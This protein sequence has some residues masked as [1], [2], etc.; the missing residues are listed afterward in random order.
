MAALR[1]HW[2]P[3]LV[4]EERSLFAHEFLQIRAVGRIFQIRLML[5]AR[6]HKPV[7]A[8]GASTKTFA[9]FSTPNVNLQE[10]NT[11][12]FIEFLVPRPL[13]KSKKLATVA[14]IFWEN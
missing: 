14:V 13:K 1:G 9:S 3:V 11:F 8:R 2:A 4:S 10:K 5:V 6:E 12:Y 7:G